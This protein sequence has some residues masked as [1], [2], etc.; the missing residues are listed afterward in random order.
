MLERTTSEIFVNS[1]NKEILLAWIANMGMQ[2]VL[3]TYA[4]AKY[5]VG[6]MLKA[7]GGVSKFLRA[8]CHEAR[9]GNSVVQDKVKQFGKILINGTEISAQDAAAFL[10]G[11]PNTACSRVYVCI[12]SSK[13]AER[14]S[15]L[16]PE[17]TILSDQK[18]WKIFVELILLQFIDSVARRNL[19][20]NFLRKNNTTF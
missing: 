9:L 2:F 4:C 20:V 5:C 15:V 18:S 8:A 16:K 7:E 1:Y 19:K 11:I 3:D 10:L 6:Y 12:N 17:T 14:I 13:P